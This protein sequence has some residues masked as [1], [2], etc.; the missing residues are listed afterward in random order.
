MMGRFV[1]EGDRGLDLEFEGELVVDENHHDV[2]FVKVIRTSSGSY[3]LT[4]DRSPRPGRVTI[5]RTMVLG[6]AE[7]VG[8]VLGF[9]RGAKSVGARLGLE[10]SRRV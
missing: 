8:K 10:T 6:S 9:S 3:V 5:K 1:V 7:E 4:R 2:G